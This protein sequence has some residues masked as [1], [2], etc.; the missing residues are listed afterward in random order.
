MTPLQINNVLDYCDSP[1]YYLDVGEL[2][3]NFEEFRQAFRNTFTNFHLA[4]SYK[5]NYVPWLC[6]WMFLQEA[7]AEVVS[8]MEYEMARQFGIPGENIIFNGPAK[9]KKEIRVAMEEGA[10]INLDSLQ[11]VQYV[12]ELVETGI[13]N[14]ITHSPQIGLRL[15]FPLFGEN[16]NTRFGLSIHDGEADKAVE[17]IHKTDK[18]DVVSLH[19]HHST[20]DRGITGFQV[21]A[22]TLAEFSISRLKDGELKYLNV[23]GSFGRNVPGMNLNRKF[24]DTLTY[25]EGIAEALSPYFIGKSWPT[26]VIEPGLSLVGTP[27]HFLS[28][29]QAIKTIEA[30][31]YAFLDSSFHNLKPSLH[32]FNLPIRIYNSDG[33]EKLDRD[34]SIVLAGYT[35][36]ESDIIGYYP[37]A[38]E[39]CVGDII[40]FANVGAYTIVFNPQFIRERPPIVVVNGDNLELARRRETLSDVLQ[41]YT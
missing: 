26:L 12:L 30:K 10:V 37:S 24:P 27:F 39:I 22:K 11:E 5:T 32:K 8:G 17:L 34:C 19:G 16:G 36:M 1:V 35:C 20:A 33:G 14:K 29:V 7:H 38:P 6:K 18:L 40:D 13:H 9:G 2:K 25:A 4:Y 15:N 21:I 3:S 31:Q 23:G 28:R 41:L